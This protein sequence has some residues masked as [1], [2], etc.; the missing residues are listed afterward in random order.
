LT[1]P[2]PEPR[3]APHE[4]PREVLPYKT[5]EKA[6]KLPDPLVA[7]LLC[8]PG[9]SCWVLFIDFFVQLGLLK[10]LGKSLALGLWVFAVLVAI[11]S[12]V[13]YRSSKKIW[14][15]RLCLLI[16]GA[17]LVFTV[18]PLGWISFWALRHPL[19]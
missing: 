17:G 11:F 18:S 4:V 12:Y 10:S 16:N 7:T 3:S 5:L 15:V 6:E 8:I 19:F 2:R 13:F 1:D 14:Y 9:L